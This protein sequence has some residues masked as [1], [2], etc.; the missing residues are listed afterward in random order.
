MTLKATGDSDAADT[1]Y[2]NEEFLQWL[3]E[4]SITPYMGTRDSIHRKNSPSYIRTKVDSDDE[5]RLRCLAYRL[6]GFCSCCTKKRF[7]GKSVFRP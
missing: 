7:L 6:V 4:R 2:G 5:D 1:T 3:A